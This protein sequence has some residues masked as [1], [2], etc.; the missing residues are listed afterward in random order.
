MFCFSEY[1]GVAPAGLRCACSAKFP[2]PSPSFLCQPW[3][4]AVLL[5][6][7]CVQCWQGLDDFASLLFRHA[8]VIDHLQIQ[9]ELRAGAEE[10]PQ[11]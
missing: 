3:L 2:H 6:L 4:I 11:A 5:F 7:M 1:V 8:Q 9:P 10:M